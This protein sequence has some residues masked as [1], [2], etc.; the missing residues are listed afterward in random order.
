MVILDLGLSVIWRPKIVSIPYGYWLWGIFLL[1]DKK[2]A[3][4][5]AQK[6]L[7]RKGLKEDPKGGGARSVGAILRQGKSRL[8]PK[9]RT[10][11]NQEN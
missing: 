8:Q 7:S 10:F 2:N 4:I 5:V 9:Y 1:Y 11:I 6:P 3:F